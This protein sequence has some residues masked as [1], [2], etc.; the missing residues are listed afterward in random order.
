MLS[1]YVCVCVELLCV[2]LSQNFFTQTAKWADACETVAVLW[3]HALRCARNNGFPCG[4]D[5]GVTVF[6]LGDF[7]VFTVD[8]DVVLCHFVFPLAFRRDAKNNFVG[9][10][11]L[12]SI[13]LGIVKR[14][15]RNI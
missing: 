3:E 9:M 6:V 5:F 1:V 15:A 4:N 11:E 13:L 10:D 14:F 7:V 8:A 12:S 2:D